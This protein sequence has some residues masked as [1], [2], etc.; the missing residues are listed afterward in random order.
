[1]RLT[2]SAMAISA[3]ALVSAGIAQ[4]DD[5]PSSVF[6]EAIVDGAASAP[7]ANDGKFASA[8]A[9]IRKRTGDNGPVVLFARRVSKFVQ[10]PQ[11]G[12]VAY[13]VGQPSAHVLYTDMA[14]Q[15]NICADGDPPLR[16]CKGQPDKLVP[17]TAICP[18]LSRPVD[19]PEVAAATQAAIAAGGMT[20]Q[21][22]A[23]AVRSAQTKAASSKAGVQ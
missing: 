7:L 6:T 23:Q 22:A 9:A 18:D 3:I 15:F 10:Q 14:G 16:M 20:P 5:A 2:I 12:R 21:Q 19:T 17:P 8:L 1:M 4:A 13:I 11:C